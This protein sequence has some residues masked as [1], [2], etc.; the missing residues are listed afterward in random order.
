MV[1]VVQRLCNWV[2]PMLWGLAFSFFL[3]M[4]NIA[5][6]TH[7]TFSLPTLSFPFPVLGV[8]L[9]ALHIVGNAVYHWTTSSVLLHFLCAPI[10]QG[11]FNWS[12]LSIT[13]STLVRNTDVQVSLCCADFSC[14]RHIVSRG[15]TQNPFSKPLTHIM[16]LKPP[17]AFHVNS[18]ILTLG[19]ACWFWGG[20]WLKLIWLESSP[21]TLD[22]G[23][24]RKK[25]NFPWV[26]MDEADLG[27]KCTKTRTCWWLSRAKDHYGLWED[28]GG[29]PWC[30]SP[31]LHLSLRAN[32]NVFH[33]FCGSLQHPFK[34]PVLL[35]LGELGFCSKRP[36]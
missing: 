30:F 32:Y 29:D 24:L 21:E 23:L 15:A 28:N 22:L 20:N 18:M 34:C 16:Y 7:T 1:A 17:P 5:L 3:W 13:M 10:H 33:G 14:F 31:R 26:P 8:K 4:N 36:K 25:P 19:P 11:P 2:G 9:K 35:K 12:H 6:C 27:S